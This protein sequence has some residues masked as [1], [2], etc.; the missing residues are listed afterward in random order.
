MARLRSRGAP[1]GAT[2]GRPTAMTTEA[3]TS[4]CG[5][6]IVGS[7]GDSGGGGDGDT[8]GDTGDDTGDD[9]ATGPTGDTPM[10]PVIGELS[11]SNPRFVGAVGVTGLGV[12]YAVTQG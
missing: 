8:G 1:P 3:T 7:G 5:T 9:G 6:I 2:R 11:L 4:S 12:A 10:L